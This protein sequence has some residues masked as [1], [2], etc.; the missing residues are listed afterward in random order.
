MNP[1]NPH[2]YTQWEL[3]PGAK[4]RLGKGSMEDI[5]YSP[6]GTLLAVACDIG[7]WLYD[8]NAGTELALLK[9]QQDPGVVSLTFS[10]DGTTLVT[11]GWYDNISLWDVHTG[12]CRSVRFV[13]SPTLGCSFNCRTYHICICNGTPCVPLIFCV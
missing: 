5:Q 11:G 4:A 1:Q 9:H 6:D 3:P 8:A 12:Q 10:H 7:V 2:P 13:T